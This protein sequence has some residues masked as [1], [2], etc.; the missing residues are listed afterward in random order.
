[1]LGAE[2][3]GFSTS[4]LIVL[5]CVMMRKCHLN[6]CPVGVATQN[7][8]FRRKFIGKSE[9]I[10]NFFNFIANDIRE[11]LARMGFKKLEDIVGRTDLISINKNVNNWKSNNIDLSKIIYNSEKYSQNGF[12]FSTKHE[13]DIDSVMDIDLIEQSKPS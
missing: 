1:M 11:E 6:T 5:G 9:Y 8:E 2:E 7:E 4:V 3:F 12:R 13:P 10:I